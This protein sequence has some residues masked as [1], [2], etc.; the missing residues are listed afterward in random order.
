M[1][2]SA[3]AEAEESFPEMKT[4]PFQFEG[5]SPNYFRCAE[6][7]PMRSPPR[8]LQDARPYFCLV[9]D[10]KRTTLQSFQ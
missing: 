7:I 10:V 6:R 5:Y 8:K 9:A 2:V 3:L 1:L 4:M